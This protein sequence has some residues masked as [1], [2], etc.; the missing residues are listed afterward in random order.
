MKKFF[1]EIFKKGRNRN[2]FILV[3]VLALTAI[4]LRVTYASFFTVKTN[5]T[6][7]I[8]TTGTL[9]VSF[10]NNS[11]S[12]SKVLLDRMSDVE[13]MHQSESSVVYIQ[14]NGNL[15]SVFTLD[16]GYNLAEFSSRQGYTL[17][18]RLVPIDYIMFAVYE[19]TG[20]E[21]VLIA[22]PISMSDLP[23]YRHVNNNYLADRY[24]L[25][26]GEIGSTS[27]GN[28]GRTYKI[29]SWLSDKAPAAV[30]YSFFYVNLEIVAEVEN[31]VMSYDISGNLVLDN[32]SVSNAKVLFHNGSQVSTTNN[33]GE[34]SFNNVYP[35]T[36]NLDIIYDGNVYSGNITVEEVNNVSTATLTSLG[37]ISANGDVW[38]TSY[39]YGTTIGKLID[40]NN[41]DEY[42]NNVGSRVFN[43]KPTYKL[44]AG[45]NETISGI[46][47]TLN[48]SNYTFSMSKS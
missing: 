34:W 41:I 36:Y 42:S 35:G 32:T 37:S 6:N 2:M 21:D 20:G 18:D 31:A 8:I 19:Y 28:A 30:S 40:Y 7:Q 44:T 10:A 27:S 46:T 13:G 5:T 38:A 9:D 14:N 1:I 15:D 12:I 22:G 17:N 39:N 23:I 16:V 33:S 25:M 47:I 48:S 11:S 29:K 43:L 4:S 26:V 3:C 45:G 24:S